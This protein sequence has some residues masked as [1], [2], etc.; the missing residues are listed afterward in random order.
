MSERAATA[1]TGAVTAHPL[2]QLQPLLA[3]HA[4]RFRPASVRLASPDPGFAP[5]G[6]QPGNPIGAL[7]EQLRTCFEPVPAPDA[8]AS[9]PPPADG[10]APRAM[11]EGAAAERAADADLLAQAR[12]EAFAAGVAEG[13]RA[14]E[15]DAGIRIS[16][17]DRLAERFAAARALEPAEAEAALQ[18]ASLHLVTAILGDAPEL[19]RETL[20]ARVAKATAAFARALAS[21]ELRLNPADLAALEGRVAW[22]ASLTARPDPEVPSG[23]F[24]IESPDTRVADS[25]ADRLH[26]LEAALRNPPGADA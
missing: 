20:H 2:P 5:S 9:E 7:Q 11:D 8:P 1:R 16:T 23:A 15:Q 19:V 6:R 18:Q 17:L 3:S 24:V 22:P 13:R 4:G 10:T 14:A 25:I 26:R 12:A 21:A